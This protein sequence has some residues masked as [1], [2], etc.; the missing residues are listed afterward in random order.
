MAA[1][2]VD[3]GV[4]CSTSLVRYRD[5]RIVE[6]IDGYDV[7]RGQKAL[8]SASHFASTA[9]SSPDF[10]EAMATVKS[11]CLVKRLLEVH[12]DTGN[13]RPRD[14]VGHSCRGRA[15]DLDTQAESIR[16]DET[17]RPPPN[18]GD[19]IATQVDDSNAYAA[20]VFA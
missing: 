12:L 8:M 6:I 14:A 4:A 5:S 18:I 20:K 11:S 9:R 16:F 19:K 3:H 1:A 7:S 2:I 17:A 10:D 15:V 13:G